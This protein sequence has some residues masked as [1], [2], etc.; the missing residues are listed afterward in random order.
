MNESVFNTPPPGFGEFS[1]ILLGGSPSGKF[2]YFKIRRYGTL[3]FVKS[4]SE[5]ISGDFL[6]LESLRKEFMV[7]MALNHPNIVRYVNFDGKEITQEYIEGL[8]LRE[9]IDQQ[10]PRLYDESFLIDTCRQIL[11]ALDYIHKEGILH[12]DLKPENVMIT[13][14]GD[15]VK[16]IDFNCALS[17]SSDLTS[18]YTPGRMA[19][20]QAENT[21]NSYTDI[22]LVGKLMEEIILNPK[23]KKGWT[24]FIKKATAKDPHQRFSSATDALKNLPQIKNSS[25]IKYLSIFLPAVLVIGVVF[26]LLFYNSAQKQNNVEEKEPD[27]L[28]SESLPENDNSNE[29][30]EVPATEMVIIKETGKT[31]KKTITTNFNSSLEEIRRHIYDYYNS[32]VMPLCNGDEKEYDFGSEAHTYELQKR[33][34]EAQA[35][36]IAFAEKYKEM[37]PDKS[38]EIDKFV[39]KTLNDNQ[40]NIGMKY[41]QK[42]NSR[43]KPE[44][45]DSLKI[46]NNI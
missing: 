11:E 44:I 42:I 2:C 26:F 32:R 7:G 30:K 28:V 5:K 20:E 38:D 21:E 36:G 8:T 45:N 24:K 46:T 17:S 22:F 40:T 9:M 34:K 19:P 39:Y 27:I 4:P 35:N 18:G 15:R 37:Y 41:K 6:T 23:L 12:L 31:T 33:L 13:K 43:I 16:I 14:V 1:R 29:I 3:Y 10:D 25:T